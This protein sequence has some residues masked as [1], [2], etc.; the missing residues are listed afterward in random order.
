MTSRLAVLILGLTLGAAPAVRAASPAAAKPDAPKMPGAHEKSYIYDLCDQSLIRPITR[1]TDA[2]LL[3]RKIS[4]RPREA[5][6]VDETDQVRLP[7]TWWQ[8]RM[9]FRPV[10]IEQM[11]NGPGSGGGPAPGTW[12]ITKGKNQGVSPGFQ[13]KDSKGVKYIIKFDPREFPESATA[14][15]AIGARLFWACGYNVPENNVAFF[16][17]SDLTVADD[18]TFTDSKGHKKKMDMSHVHQILASVAQRRD[19]SYRCLASKYLEGKP[20]GPFEYSGRRRDDPDDLVP[21]QLRRELRG[22]W[23]VAAWVNHA[24]ARGANSL[25]MWETEG[26]RGFVRHY[27]IDFGSIL[28]SSATPIQRDYSTGSEYY[29]DFGAIVREVP[30]LGLW[31]AEWEDVV[32]P[33]LP[34]VGFVEADR[35]DP[36]SWRPDYPNPSFD[37]RTPRDVRW[38]ARIV[39]A[40]TDDYI[41]AAVGA[42]KF[43]DPRAT[44]YLV[45]VLIQRRDKLVHRWLGPNAAAMVNRP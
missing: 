44:D 8:P 15:D 41:R 19:G 39:G 14:A 2:A 31:E 11:M 22:L 29:L 1:A 28:G 16:K 37:E 10:S 9:G 36:V 25:D 35:F 18:A 4:H 32:D 5:A 38:G 24:D 45:R 20:L 33:G 12:T 6:N 26:G 34:S 13:I 23:T 27:L 43:S 7:S 3:V 21:H 30:T 17:A 42:G 40:F